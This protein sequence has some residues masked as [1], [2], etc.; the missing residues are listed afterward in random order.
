MQITND[1]G[2]IIF[3][4]LSYE[5]MG[6]AFDVFNK[7]GWGHTENVYHRALEVALAKKGIKF[8]SEKFVSIEYEGEKIARKFLDLLVEDS[9]I[10]ELKVLPQM[11]YVHINQVMSYLK[12]TNMK[13]A[14]LI[15]FTKDGV[16]SRRIINA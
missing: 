12:S 14:I 16:K 5:I 4:E 6:L 9:I 3:P 10:L 11:G 7:I 2:K 15:Y 1:V 13:L 8:C